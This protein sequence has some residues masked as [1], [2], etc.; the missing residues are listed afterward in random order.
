VEAQLHAGVAG[1]GAG[2]ASGPATAGVTVT[3]PKGA[4][5]TRA[6]QAPLPRMSLVVVSCPLD[7]HTFWAPFGLVPVAELGDNMQ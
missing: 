3:F 7:W 6:S 5:L 1:E 4:R 2:C